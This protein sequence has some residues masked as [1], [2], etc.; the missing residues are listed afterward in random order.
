M[1]KQTYLLFLFPL[2]LAGC[3]GY[4]RTEGKVIFEDDQSPLTRGVVIL[5]TDTHQAKGEIQPDGTFTV[6]SFKKNDGLPSGNYRVYLSGTVSEPE[7]GTYTEVDPE[8]MALLPRHP[9]SGPREP[10]PLIDTKY[11]RV[12]TSGISYNTKDGPTLNITVQRPSQK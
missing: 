1:T 12:E 4:V 6:G 5:Q 3:N 2:L 7:T 10:L 9:A 11:N 8:K